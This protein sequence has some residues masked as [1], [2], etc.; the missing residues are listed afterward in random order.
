MCCSILL[1]EDLYLKNHQ[2]LMIHIQ[3]QLKS[4]FLLPFSQIK[5][6]Q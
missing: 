3:L 2:D 5:I 1:K 4:D 6:V